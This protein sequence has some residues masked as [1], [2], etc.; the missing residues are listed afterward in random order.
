MASP[1]TSNS[2]VTSIGSRPLP[3][4]ADLQPYNYAVAGQY[5]VGLVLLPA[6]PSHRLLSSP[7]GY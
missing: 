2:T 4:H 3:N 7:L 1:S 5:V 6:L